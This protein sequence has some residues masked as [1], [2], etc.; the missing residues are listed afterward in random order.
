MTG[1]LVVEVYKGVEVEVFTLLLFALVVLIGLPV[2]V[3]WLYQS[4]D[5]LKPDQKIFIFNL[6]GTYHKTVIGRSYERLNRDRIAL[7]GGNP[8]LALQLFG[9]E[10]AFAPWPF[11]LGYRATSTQ[12]EVPVHASQMYTDAKQTDVPR[13]RMEGDG[14]L[15]FRLSD[16]PEYLAG[17]FP[18]FDQSW[19]SIIKK[20]NRDLTRMTCLEDK[21]VS[22]S[23]EEVTHEHKVQQVALIFHAVLNKAMQDAMREAATHFT[24]STLGSTTDD[25]IR[26]R[27]KYEKMVR[28][29]VV[30]DDGSVFREAR[31]FD[32]KGN[33]A[34]SLLVG[35]LV[36]ENIQLQAAQETD[37]EAI[38]AIDAVFIGKQKGEAQLLVE[39][40][41]RIGQADGIK[42]LSTALGLDDTQ[43]AYMLDVLRSSGKE[44][45][46]TQL[47]LNEGA[48]ESL[49]RILQGTR[50]TR[51]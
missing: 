28:A 43:A 34:E 48:I 36:I 25:I 12:F 1:P 24:F 9:M 29:L 3:Y 14:T 4:L 8:R 37:S 33:P 11:K 41:T 45:N 47:G 30:K 44:V 38:K 32:D 42:A 40:L 7:K 6:G 46:L 22:I 20:G 31:L 15:Q 50:A 5:P 13:V 2:L 19:A 51:P 49:K 18:L 23:G 26:E 10:F 35:D 21:R 27:E 39:K 17:V 16:N